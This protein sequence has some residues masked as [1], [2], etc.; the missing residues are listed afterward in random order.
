MLLAAGFPAIIVV[1]FKDKLWRVALTILKHGGCDDYRSRLY[2]T[3]L[4]FLLT[5]LFC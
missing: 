5:G 4:E 2:C 1:K 3:G